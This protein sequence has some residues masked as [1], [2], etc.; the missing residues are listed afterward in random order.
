MD[1][2]QTNII[3][4]L[5]VSMLSWI[6]P[7]NP[8]RTLMDNENTNLE[9][10]L[11]L[12]A[13]FTVVR[14]A[15]DK[16]P[17]K[18]LLVNCEHFKVTY[19]NIFNFFK[20]IQAHC[21][22]HDSVYYLQTP[23]RQIAPVIFNCIH[24]AFTCD[25]PDSFID[26]HT[27]G[28]YAPDH[29]MDIEGRTNSFF[30]MKTILSTFKKTTT[31]I[32]NPHERQATCRHCDRSMN[33]DVKDLYNH[34]TVRHGRLIVPIETT[35]PEF[36]N[37]ISEKTSS[38]HATLENEQYTACYQC[39]SLFDN[40]SDFLIHLEFIP[41]H[42]Q[43]ISYCSICKSDNEI[44]DTQHIYTYH[45]NEIKCPFINCGYR[46]EHYNSS[47]KEHLL[48]HNIT[49]QKYPASFFK[50]SSYMDI[51]KFI[52]S[53]QDRQSL[54][55][56]TP[57]KFMGRT[58]DVPYDV[59]T[60]QTE[61]QT[62][63][64]SPKFPIKGYKNSNTALDIVRSLS[65]HVE[66]LHENTKEILK[67]Q[68]PRIY[69][70]HKIDPD[71]TQTDGTYTL[72][73]QIQYP[74]VDEATPLGFN[75][76]TFPVLLYGNNVLK[77][78]KITQ[79]GHQISLNITENTTRF[80]PSYICPETNEAI[81]AHMGPYESNF[82]K[83]YFTN[84]T[85]QLYGL[86]DYQGVLF[87]EANIQD[88]IFPTGMSNEFIQQLA[89]SFIHGL[90]RLF[91]GPRL[92][93]VIGAISSNA[94]NTK[95][96]DINISRFNA[97]LGI[98]CWH[99]KF[100]FKNPAEKSQKLLQ[101]NQNWDYHVSSIAREKLFT[102]DSRKTYEGHHAYQQWVNEIFADLKKIAVQ[103]KSPLRDIFL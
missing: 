84:L 79:G 3:P 103:M 81:I 20:T 23:E 33:K 61:D 65:L 8:I 50:Y 11:P 36:Y 69:H 71:F 47:L 52:Q 87:V 10:K 88:L 34:A 42:E 40:I 43:L 57:I 68:I 26:H 25:N 67:I 86:K 29:I 46:G 5:G 7:C 35:K 74:P 60:R 55:P 100:V 44:P 93:V 97:L 54:N 92:I 6:R 30:F 73:G 19:L 78:I 62:L 13:F 45:R 27:M 38:F 75:R 51:I 53:S 2:C 31:A 63:S 18:R 22:W 76:N 24:C 9:E 49:T 72:F 96:V 15:I 41:G 102:F 94:R 101:R 39:T 66:N 95:I 83:D 37:V 70:I 89:L 32:Y 48:T 4:H 85:N 17:D 77:N 99:A 98:L 58:V 56:Q 21:Q 91:Q 82:R 16:N 64:I 1:E 12:H 59:L 90:T 28:V 14:N 80:W